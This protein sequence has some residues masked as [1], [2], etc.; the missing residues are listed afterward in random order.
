M[1]TDMF[2]PVT[3]G[4]I[5]LSNRMVMAPMTRNRA[6]EHHAPHDLNVTYYQQRATAGLIITE[7]S[8]VSPEGVGY[9]GTPGIY[10]DEQVAGWQKV[11]N[12]VHAEGGHIFIQL[13]YCGRISHPDLL[14]DK[15]IPVAPSAIKPE[16]EAVTLEG[17]KAFVTPRAL[18]TNEIADIVAQYRHA[19][20]MAK[21]A[22]F[23]GVEVHAA[24][25]YLIDQFLRDGSNKRTD[26]YG[27]S[28]ENRMRL[29]NEVLDA[30]IEV[31]P[32]HR[33]AVRLTPENSFNS[34]SDSNP[35]ENFSYFITQLNPR[36]LAYVHV[37][38]GDM[39]TKSV[40]ID[41]RVLRDCYDG[42]Y[43]A[44]NGYDKARAQT[45][46]NNGNCDLVAL[47]VPFL[48]N[49]DLVKR[50]QHDLPLNE[51]DFATF[52]GGDEHGYVDYPFAEEVNAESV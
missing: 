47:G 1:S 3:L 30:V 9:P 38:E 10:S 40:N 4:D 37:L 25:G 48:S 23:D 8:Q 33:V 51:V 34:M 52:Y 28:L 43:M 31:W 14:P 35:L 5:K 2:S 49:P 32:S 11:T 29:L 16:G 13:W 39:M 36:K 46:L 24:N 19:A 15:Q 20:K 12:A 21:K 42:L 41:Y 6:D 45:A 44:N 26:E 17:M 27:G 7:A 18:E 50:Y 22:G